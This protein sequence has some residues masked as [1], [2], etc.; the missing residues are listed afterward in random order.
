MGYSM[1][2]DPEITAKAYRNE[3]QISPKKSVEVCDML[4]GRDVEKALNILDEVIDGDRAVPYKKHDK[5]VAHQKGI[6]SGGYP[7]KVCKK[8]KSLIEECKANAEN[9]GLDTDEMFIKHLTA[10]KGSPVEGFRPRAF[11]RSSPHNTQ[12]T[13][14]EIILE[15]KEE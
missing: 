9:K 5:R 12:T 4:R 13:N 3:F 15:E 1:D 7:K 14:I 8:I 11:G 10:Y 6:G 2:P